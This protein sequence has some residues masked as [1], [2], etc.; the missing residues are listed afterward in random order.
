MKKLIMF[1]FVS[2]LAGSVAFAQNNNS[3]VKQ[4]GND[5][6]ATVAQAGAQHQSL[7]DQDAHFGSGHTAE[8]TQESGMLNYSNVMQRQANSE[9]YILQ[10]G[11]ENESRTRQAGYNVVD[12]LQEGDYNILGAY[13]N[14]GNAAY[15]KN[16][17]GMWAS[18][19][20]N[21]DLDQLGNSN[22][23]G[24]TQEHHGDATVLQSGNSNEAGV[25]QGGA[26][27]GA[28][29]EV[30]IAQ[31]G[32][33]NMADAYQSG[34]GNKATIGQGVSAYTSND[35][36]ASIT[37]LGDGNNASFSLTWG[38]LNDVTVDQDGNN[39]YSEFSVKYGDENTVSADVEGSSNR[40]RFHVNSDWGSMSSGNTINIQKLGNTNYVAG[41]IKGGSNMVDIVQNG[42]NNMIGTSWY[43]GDGVSIT[44]N[45]N[46][47]DVDQMSNGNSSLNS[48]AGNNNSISVMQ[49]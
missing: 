37:Q 34:E 36:D 48:V 49:N 20:N 4:K 44:G 6:S 23:A 46:M 1:V 22:E 29:N 42:N 15:Q 35:N 38:D 24:V 12:V 10:T 17:G 32:D 19:M 8:V 43:T 27:F 16:G 25:R 45:S 47:V 28:L 13:G 39:N 30:A 14:L 26:A 3:D 9:A 2:M 33:I 5:H 11:S 18:D 7:V 21:L 31:H 40:T 41:S